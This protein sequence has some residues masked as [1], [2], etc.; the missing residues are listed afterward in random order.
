ML[1]ATHAL[2]DAVANAQDNDDVADAFR[3]AAVA[4]V[5]LVDERRPLSGEARDEAH[6]DALEALREVTSELGYGAGALEVA[7]REAYVA[8]TESAHRLG[9]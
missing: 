1:D 9:Y 8:A 5:A 4:L 7:A 2:Q 3:D 6:A